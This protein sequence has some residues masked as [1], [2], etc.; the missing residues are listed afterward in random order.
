[1]TSTINASHLRADDLTASERAALPASHHLPRFLIIGAGSRGN[2]YAQ[3]VHHSGL[4]IIAGVADPIISKRV[5]LGA[6]YI[7]IPLPSRPSHVDAQS[8]ISE[9]GRE[10]SERKESGQ[11]DERGHG[12][13]TGRREDEEFDSWQQF[14]KYEVSRR[15]REAAGERVLSGVD[16]AFVCTQDRTHREI[17]EALA[18]LGLSIMC[19]KPMATSLA[20]C[21][22]MYRALEGPAAE[23]HGQGHDPMRTDPNR[24]VSGTRQT[25]N[26]KTSR[27]S[28][29]VFSIGHVLRYSPHN[30]FLR[31]LLL[32]DRSIGEILSIEHTE[33]VGWW[34]YSHSYVRGNWRKESASSPALLAKSCHD[35]DFL[36]WLLCS[37][38]DHAEQP[39]LPTTVSSAGRLSYF[40]KSRKPLGAGTATNCLKCP[41]ERTC[42]YSAKTIYLEKHLLEGNR[43]WPVDIVVP[44][45]ESVFTAEGPEAADQRLLQTLGEDYDSSAPRETIDGRNWYGRCVWESDNDV[46]DDQTVTIIWDEELDPNGRVKLDRGSKTALFHMIAPTE[47]QCER[48]GRI[49]GTHGEIE[50]DSYTIK[51]YTFA[52]G[53]RQE[54]Q[55]KRMGG[56]HGG[57][58]AG[59]AG[60]FVKAVSAVINSKMA[61]EEAQ[62][63][64]IGCTVEEAFRSHA[65]VFAAE[66]ARR[67]EKV[68][69]WR[70]WWRE[71]VEEV[72]QG[73]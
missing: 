63:T 55:P 7:W 4:G 30:M 59:L 66:K 25:T 57:G 29:Q 46:C 28:R 26:T 32:Q 35:I 73:K 56:G 14:L 11:G 69:K 2:A 43:G 12:G 49:Y 37:R 18:P 5:A 33:P 50:Y 60:Q 45:I 67:E 23:G 38:L 42:N 44:D 64:Y 22:A 71:N 40:K 10:G 68:I 9:D 41:I 54:F 34:H 3:A 70:D 19:E 39:H 65:L 13:S 48:R 36:L 27:G 17:V 61:A 53:K 58:D 21:L 6:Q 8:S 51:V 47:K 24:E 16:G 20:D 15:S 31:S 62:T 72:L 1:M 52:D